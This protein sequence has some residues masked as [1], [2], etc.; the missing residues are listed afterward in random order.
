M[1]LYSLDISELSLA[2]YPVIFPQIIKE[3]SSLVV[4][5]NAIGV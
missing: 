3:F 1:V 4:K 5:S 2:I